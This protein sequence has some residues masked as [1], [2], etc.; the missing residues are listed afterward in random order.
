MLH[1]FT[2]SR[3]QSSACLCFRCSENG[4]CKSASLLV[5]RKRLFQPVLPN[6]PQEGNLLF[7]RAV[8]R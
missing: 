2:G 1:G 3:G 5:N 6:E 8:F 7:L 4:A